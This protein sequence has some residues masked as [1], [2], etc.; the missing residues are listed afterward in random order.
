MKNRPVGAECSMRT[1]KLIERPDEDNS[2]FS[3][4]LW[5]CLKISAICSVSIFMDF[6]WFSENLAVTFAIS[7]NNVTKMV[8]V[9]EK[10]RLLWRSRMYLDEY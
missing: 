8:V 7:L 1:N 5:K 4:I 10:Q 6:V 3:A 9:I 2:Y